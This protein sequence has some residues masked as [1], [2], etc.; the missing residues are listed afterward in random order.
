MAAHIYGSVYKGEINVIVP[1][2]ELLTILPGAHTLVEVSATAGS[3]Y[4][5]DKLMM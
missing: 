1:A 5:S 3:M 2:F 4:L